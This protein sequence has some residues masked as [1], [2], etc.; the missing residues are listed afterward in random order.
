MSFGTLL[1]VLVIVADLVLYLMG[2]LPGEV[3]AMFA[4][5]ALAILLSAVPLRWGV[6]A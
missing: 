4:A 6:A 1:A 5:L 3:A 2:K